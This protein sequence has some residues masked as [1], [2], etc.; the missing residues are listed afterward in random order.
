MKPIDPKD[1]AWD[2]AIT[3]EEWTRRQHQQQERPQDE[4]PPKKKRRGRRS[5]GV[6]RQRNGWFHI[7]IQH[8]TLRV[9]RAAK[10]KDREVAK[11]LLVKMLNDIQSGTFGEAPRPLT[12]SDLVE[13]LK[14]DYK[15]RRL[16]SWDRA[17]RSIKHLRK[18]FSTL[19]AAAITRKLVSQY[20]AKRV[21]DG[22]KAGT[23]RAECAYLKRMLR[24]A[25]AEKAL[26]AMPVF[27]A[28]PTSPARQG[29]FTEE[30][31]LLVVSHLDQPVADLVYALW[32]TGWRRREV[33]FLKWSDVDMKAGEITLTEDRSKTGDS[34]IFPFGASASLAKI[35]KS[36]YLARGQGSVYVFERSHG[37]PVKDFRGAWAKACKAVGLTKKMPHDFRRSRA[38]HLSRLGVSEKVIMDLSGWKT[39]AM[40]DRYNITSRRDL[41]EAL[42]RA[43]K[44]KSGTIAS[45]SDEAATEGPSG[46]SA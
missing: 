28:L 42:E 34:R 9:R 2:R 32:I 19:P 11:A 15:N 29:F 33:Q 27:P 18:S 43:E 23:V 25:C 22:A 16:R 3:Y 46:Q 35:I 5:L 24:L 8:E 20:M 38:R 21:N 12:F 44:S 1:P 4:P 30:E 7:D 13:L 36:R 17:E 41:A 45:Q 31:V 37:Q 6:L 10:T 39:R 40:L 14:A 26:R